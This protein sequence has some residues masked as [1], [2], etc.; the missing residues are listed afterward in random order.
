MEITETRRELDRY[1]LAVTTHYTLLQ[2]LSDTI[3][4]VVHIKP[5][6]WL[7]PLLITNSGVAVQLKSLVELASRIWNSNL[8]I[9][10]MVTKLQSCPPHPDTSHTWFQEP[11]RFEDALGRIIPIPSEYNWSV[12]VFLS[13]T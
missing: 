9:M 11:V 12:G 13:I 8:Q 3:S 10:A 1:G 2:R 6:C 4:G 7:K 5:S